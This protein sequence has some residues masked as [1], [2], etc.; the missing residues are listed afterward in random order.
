MKSEAGKTR[1]PIVGTGIMS[2]S[3]QDLV[4]VRDAARTKPWVESFGVSQRN[5][6]GTGNKADSQPAK[7]G[8]VLMRQFEHVIIGGIPLAELCDPGLLFRR[9]A[10]EISIQRQAFVGSRVRHHRVK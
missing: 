1:T 2:N 10:R 5:V 4:L 7:P 3:Q 6:L 9:D 8:R